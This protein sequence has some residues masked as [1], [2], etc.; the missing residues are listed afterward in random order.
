MT[1]TCFAFV[2]IDVINM[3]NVSKENICTVMMLINF[4]ALFYVK[5]L[6]STIDNWSITYCNKIHIFR[7]IRSFI[8]IVKICILNFK[9]VVIC[10]NYDNYI[11]VNVY[12][13]FKAAES[14][15]EQQHSITCDGYG[16]DFYS[17]K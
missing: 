2:Y 16:F 6:I 5:R 4:N 17:E 3:Y 11:L 14:V 1:I 12:M 9:T 7:T 8:I 13:Q 15:V 10:V